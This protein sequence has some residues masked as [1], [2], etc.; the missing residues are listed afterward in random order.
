[1]TDTYDLPQPC[2]IGTVLYQT[3]GTERVGHLPKVHSS[4]S[5]ANQLMMNTVSSD[6]GYLDL[7]ATILITTLYKLRKPIIEERSWRC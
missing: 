3:R 1:M 6:P 2:N 5:D 7:T 4:G